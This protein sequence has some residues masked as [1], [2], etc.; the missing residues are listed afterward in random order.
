MTFDINQEGKKYYI[1]KKEEVILNSGQ[2]S[3]Y[4]DETKQE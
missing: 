4:F 1:M 2:R 3:G